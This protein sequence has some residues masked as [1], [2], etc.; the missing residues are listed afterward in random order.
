[1]T[2]LC[3]ETFDEQ[4]KSALLLVLLRG[5]DSAFKRLHA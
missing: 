3:E 2:L 5:N 4:N 1:L